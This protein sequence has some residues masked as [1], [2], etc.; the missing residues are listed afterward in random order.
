MLEQTDLKEKKQKNEELEI[1][2]KGLEEKLKLLKQVKERTDEKPGQPIA[3]Y[4]EGFSRDDV[5]KIIDCL[6][7]SSGALELGIEVWLNWNGVSGIS[8]P[9]NNSFNTSSYASALPPTSSASKRQR[10]ASLNL[11]DVSGISNPPNNSFTA[12]SYESELDIESWL[13]CDDVSGVL[14]QPTNRLND[15]SYESASAPTSSAKK[16]KDALHDHDYT[17]KE[18]GNPPKIVRF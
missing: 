2:T 7:T 8:S 15:P 17:R 18:Q 12:S 16:R 13:N 11:N 14:N 1:K 9:P 10:T 4:L 6:R 3:S 5:E